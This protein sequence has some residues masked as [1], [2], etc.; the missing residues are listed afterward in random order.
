MP[1]D[2][3]II[4]QGLLEKMDSENELVMVLGHEIG[5]FAHRDHLRGLGNTILIQLLLSFFFDWGNI[6][7]Y[8]IN[9]TN[10]I[11]NAQYSQTQ[12]INADQFGLDLLN[13]YYGHV[14]GATDFFSKLEAE[15]QGNQQIAFL[16]SHPL[17][18]KRVQKLKRLIKT[19]DYRVGE[20]VSLN[21]IQRKPKK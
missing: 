13:K 11:L 6:A 9:I 15:N 12:E 21:F 19:K 3:I 20:K 14:A 17:P 10:H 4:Y 1:G 16:S 2:V 18:K 7:D 8:S 5:H